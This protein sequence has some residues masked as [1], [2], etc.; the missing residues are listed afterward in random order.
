LNKSD[1]I[2][3]A[4]HNGM[5][6]SAI[7]R[8]LKIRGY[9][10]L[11]TVDH[12]ILDLTKQQQVDDFFSKE[13]PDVVILAAAKVGGIL[14]NDTFPA[15][16]IYNNLMIQTNVIHSSYINNVD[17]LLFLGSGCIYP[18]ILPQ[19][20]KE[21][22][23][24]T[25]QLEKTNE[26]YA[27]AKIAGLKMCESYNKQFGTN[28]FSVMPCNIYGINDNYSVLESHV[29]PAL[30]RKFDEA[31][32]NNLNEVTIWGSGEA[33]RE[34][35]HV[36]DLANA[37]VFLL[38][39]YHENSYVNVGYGKDISISELAELISEISGFKGEIVFDRSKPDGTPKKLLDSSKLFSMGW[40]SNINLRNG[41][42]LVFDDYQLNKDYYRN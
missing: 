7:V 40:K 26:A 32:S 3:V 21:E 39:N 15:D 10:N 38:E 12:K 9:T 30:I 8:E 19:P 27:I 1:K 31:V 24:L 17:K 41:L 25:G 42:K 28:Y 33:R 4:G 35:M 14:A 2:F 5:V 29:V 37:C 34:F 16:F 20:I 11:L 36:E 6:G 13:G 22:Y 23:L 18:K